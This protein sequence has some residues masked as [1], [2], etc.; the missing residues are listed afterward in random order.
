MLFSGSNG[1]SVS[2]WLNPNKYCALDDWEPSDPGFAWETM[3]ETLEQ[4]NVTWKL[5][6]GNDNFDDNGFAWFSNYQHAQPGNPLYDKGMHSVNST[7]YYG[8]VE[9]FENDVEAGTLPQVSWL[10]GPAKLSEHAANVR[11]GWWW[12]WWWWLSRWWLL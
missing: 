6:Q 4:A 11:P 2:G 12:W 1:L 7:S 10:V 3:G 8:F 5:Y 9:A